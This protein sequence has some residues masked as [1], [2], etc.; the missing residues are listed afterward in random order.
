MPKILYRTLAFALS[1]IALFAS[2]ANARDFAQERFERRA[3]EAVL[4]SYPLVAGNQMVDGGLAAGQKINQIAFFSQPPNWKFQQPTTN[5]STLYLQLIFDVKQGPA[6]VE[7]PPEHSSI[8]LFG[9]FL[10]IWQRPVADI[11]PK[12][13]DA[14]KGGKYFIFYA[15]DPDISVP[16]G[17]YPVPLQTYRG[18]GTQRVILP[19]LKPETL[20]TANAYIHSGFRQYDYAT[21]QEYP[22]MDIFDKDYASTFPLDHTYFDRLQAIINSEEVQELDKYSMG[23]LSSIG[24][25]RGGSF[26]P[27]VEQQ[28]VL[29]RIMQRAHEELQYF[30]VE[31]TPKRWGV[32]NQ[33]R[34]PAPLSFL[35]SGND[36]VDENQVY[37]DDRAFTFYT[38]ISAPAKLGKATAYLITAK[39]ADGALLDSSRHY[40]LTVP[41]N[42]PVS[43][44]W[45]LTVYDVETGTFIH[46]GN[47]LAVVSTESPIHNPDGTT[48]I[49][50]GPAPLSEDENFI[51]TKGSNTFFVLFRFYGPQEDYRNNTWML[52][53]IEKLT[54]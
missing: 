54:N 40:R 50:I 7:I 36:F 13:D 32:Q 16:D 44:F 41:A 21:G 5:N 45:S 52:N 35:K 49:H 28:Q 33:W 51:S 48:E 8:G 37:V 20:A 6:V 46:E 43:Q 1:L 24:I 11:G 53:D 2:T 15:N 18:Y 26:E 17:Y 27:D 4:W 9:T 25:R 31:R 42:V 30:V 29:D 38:Y 23:L 10:D 3:Y 19:D 12:G 14:G 47:P 34:Y 22:K 39:D